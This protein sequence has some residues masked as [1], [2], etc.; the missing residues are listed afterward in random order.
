MRVCDIEKEVNATMQSACDVLLAPPTV[1]E[2]KEWDQWYMK[3]VVPKVREEMFKG[4]KKVIVEFVSVS[5]SGQHFLASDLT[6]CLNKRMDKADKL[7]PVGT[8][9][10]NNNYRKCFVSALFSCITQVVEA[11]SFFDESTKVISRPC[12][13]SGLQELILVV[14]WK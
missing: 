1:E 5:G 6:S 8:Y 14:S 4:Q 3:N 11:A 12:P 2:I 9:S 10:S 7:V 13:E